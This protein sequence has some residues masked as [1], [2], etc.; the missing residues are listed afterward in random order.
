[1]SDIT[2]QT[3]GQAQDTCYRPVS[4][5]I[6]LPAFNE[7]VALPLTLSCIQQALA[8]AD[9]DYEILVVD[10]G[11]QDDT[12]AV[13][14]AAGTRVI[15]HPYN[16]GN[17]AAVK[18]GLRNARGEVTVLLDADG[19]HDP[20]DIR[21]LVE[22]IGLYDLV[23]GARDVMSY[24][25][26]Y[27][28]LVNSVYNLF[29]SYITG[30]PIPDLTSGFRA[31]RT[32]QARQ[33]L[34]LLPNTFSYP[35]TMT[36]AFLRAGY[37]VGFVP[38][39]TSPRVGGD[40]KIRIF[41]DGARFLTILFKIATLFSPLKVFLPLSLA[42]LVTGAAYGAH[43][44]ILFHKFRNMATVLLVFGISLFALGLISEQIALLRFQHTE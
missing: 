5:T 36:I 18:T 6:L 20:A 3:L 28:R 41:S 14:R 31:V 10:D 44:L 15:S 12:A 8:T 2:P 40:S 34:Y 9:F 23:V 32:T 29:A 1:M 13:A 7:E 33:F 25:L 24:Q 11:S 17:G 4:V 37:S 38:I 21:R 42:F 39:T 22:Q 26:W 27:R 35:T 43:Q 19:Q 16:K 30:V